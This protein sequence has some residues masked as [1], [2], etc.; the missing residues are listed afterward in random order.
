MWR[1]AASSAVVALL[2]SLAAITGD[3]LPAIGTV[4]VVLTALAT[5]ALPRFGLTSSGAMVVTIGALLVIKPAATPVDAA[6]P[7]AAALFVAAVVG[8]TTAWI[9]GVLSFALRGHPLPKPELPDLTVPYSILLAVLAGGFTL[10][11]LL[12]FPDSNAWW[13]VLTVAIILQP[14]RDKLW[15][16]L[17]ARV[18][19]TVLG[20]TVAAILAVVLPTTIAPA[21]V[22]F[23]A[24]AA[25]VIL[26]VRGAPYWQ[27]ATA[28]TVTVVMLTFDHDQLLQGDLERILFTLLAAAVTAAAVVLLSILPSS[29]RQA[30]ASQ[31][32]H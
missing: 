18:L 20:G 29:R 13:T 14:T 27:S 31:N 11:S 17:G 9:A 25:N 4:L 15:S 12:V 8:V 28:V 7:W 2:A 21:A 24:L 26:T 5:S 10:V 3:A 22:G 32:R 30:S 6:G 1:M 16:K 23:I 19:G